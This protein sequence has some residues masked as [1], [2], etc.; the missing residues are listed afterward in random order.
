MAK[1]ALTI[2]IATLLAFA[3]VE[4]GAP[5]LIERLQGTKEGR[6]QEPAE[7]SIRQ[8]DWD[9]LPDS[10]VAWVEIPSTNVDGLVAQGNEQS[11][12]HS[13]YNNALGLGTYGTSYIDWECMPESGYAAVY[14]HRMDD[15]S[16]FADV[17]KYSDRDYA[18]GTRRSTGTHEQTTL[19]T[20]SK[21][22]PSTC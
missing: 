13:L 9:S 4:S 20:S 15:G 21:W 22:L 2:C 3:F 18:E 7:G 12:D 17:A 5:D 14:G 16:L 8:I 6:T 19:V 10:V 1:A 11:P